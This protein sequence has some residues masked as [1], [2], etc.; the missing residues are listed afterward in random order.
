LPALI[1][2]GVPSVAANATSTLAL[3]PG[4]M[5]SSWVYL[6]GV[7]SVCGVNVMPIAI[8]TVMGGVSGIILLLLTP[9]RIFYGILP[10]L[11]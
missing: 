11:L 6:D 7:N 9:S 4:G 5:A 10:W 8:V 1:S 2:V 3:F